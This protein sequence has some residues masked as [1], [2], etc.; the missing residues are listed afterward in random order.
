MVILTD[1]AFLCLILMILTMTK[2]F[3]QRQYFDIAF[4]VG[5]VIISYTYETYFYITLDA[6]IPNLLL[7]FSYDDGKCEKQ[8]LFDLLLRPNC[9]RE[10]QDQCAKKNQFLNRFKS[11][12]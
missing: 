9:L 4:K 6:V 7:F 10:G 8:P 12:L 3:A 1:M 11:F 5:S 2:Y